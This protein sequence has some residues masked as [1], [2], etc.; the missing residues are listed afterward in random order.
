MFAPLRYY[1]SSK[2]P[3]FYPPPPVLL[4]FAWIPKEDTKEPYSIAVISLALL[5]AYNISMMTLLGG[6]G[7]TFTPILFIETSSFYPPPPTLSLHI[8]SYIFHFSSCVV[9]Q[10]S[11]FGL[12]CFINFP[13]LLPQLN[14]LKL[15]IGR[16]LGLVRTGGRISTGPSSALF[17][18]GGG[19]HV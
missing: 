9:S 4:V 6:G 12:F 10:Q 15:D 16:P 17:G 2:F 14:Y 7:L 8:F 3:S 1:S 18:K 11:C 13:F 19:V 5:G